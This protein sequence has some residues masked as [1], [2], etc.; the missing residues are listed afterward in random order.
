MTDKVL[1][2]PYIRVPENAW[3]TQVLLYW[4]QVGSIIP[5]E[6]ISQP[7]KLGKYMGELI[8]EE[9]VKPVQ[10]GNYIHEIPNFD[11]AFFKLIDQN[12]IIQK[13][14]FVALEK[15]ETFRI[16]IEKFSPLIFDLCDI[17]L[18]RDVGNSWYEVE[19]L[20][21]D[22]Y[23]AY[24]ASVLGKSKEL[25]MEPITDRANSLSVYSKSPDNISSPTDILSNLRMGVLESILP[26]PAE[27]IPVVELVKFKNNHFDLLSKFRR[28][29]ESSL[30]D[31][32]LISDKNLRG[33]KVHLF[34]DELKDERDQIQALMHERRWPK[35][36]F[37]TLATAMPI[38]G[39]LATGI[40]PLAL[41]GLPPLV[42]AIHS[43]YGEIKGKKQKTLSS[44][45]AYVAMAQEKFGE[46][47]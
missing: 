5:S 24:L 37:G 4:D 17:G 8:H 34:K 23:M 9:L 36:I 31:I 20:T 35:P 45:L 42:L 41:L 26:T 25:Q 12:S 18:A 6:Y 44:P 16:H 39:T 29:V 30:I 27:G 47:R 43:A 11:E 28:H 14:R 10:P 3:F 21:A 15:R 46:S 40:T 33:E 13:R 22:L 7:E 32:A 19:S 2:F 38:I 1:Y